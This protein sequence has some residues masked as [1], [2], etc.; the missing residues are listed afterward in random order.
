VGALTYID[1][2]TDLLPQ[3]ASAAPPTPFR[4]AA[5]VELAR[6]VE[7]WLRLIG[8]NCVGHEVD[9]GVGIADLVGG[10]GSA[11]VFRNRKRQAHPITDAV[12]LRFLEFCSVARTEAEVRV[13][14]NRDM[15]TLVRRAIDPLA[16]AGLLRV[17]D[18]TFRARKHPNDPFTML[19]A[20]ELKL[21]DAH[22]GVRQASSYRVFAD[23]AFL[24][25]P[26]SRVTP[27]TLSITRAAGIG[28]LA[29]HP[30]AVEVAIDPDP[31]SL[32]T[33]L[34]RRLA[35][36]RTLAASMNA[37]QRTAGS[38]RGRFA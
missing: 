1:S 33:P 5:E 38:A 35:A 11:R 8:A 16:Q 13:W 22:R 14:A 10:V 29:V 34:R 28:L 27:T 2:V 3:S 24:A 25:L 32:A 26:A 21:R 9:A 12:Q 37:A 31:S 4:F 20:V 19:V 30:A 23:L 36:E 6:P 7:D 17:E 15:S 18:G